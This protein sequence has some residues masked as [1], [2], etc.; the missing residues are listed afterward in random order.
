MHIEFDP[1]LGLFIESF[2]KN[3]PQSQVKKKK[4]CLSQTCI[5]SS[6]KNWYTI[7]QI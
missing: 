2:L 4:K 5:I 1:K 3:S 6:N 7:F